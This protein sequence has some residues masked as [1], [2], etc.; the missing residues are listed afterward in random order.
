[1][2]PGSVYDYRYR[3]LYSDGTHSAYRTGSFTAPSAPG[4][5]ALAAHTTT[6]LSLSCAAPADGAFAP[7]GYRWRISANGTPSSADPEHTSAGNTHQIT[8]LT[9]GTVYWVEVRAEYA[10]GGYS[11]WSADLATATQASAVPPFESG[12][13]TAADPYIAAPEN[14]SSAQDIKARARSSTEDPLY[15]DTFAIIRFVAA[16]TGTHTISV[17][18]LHSDQDID[19]HVLDGDN[20]VSSASTTDNESVNINLQADSAC[21][22]HLIAYDGWGSGMPAGL[23]HLRLGIQAPGG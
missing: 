7:T 10:N 15:N 14:F 8:D 9:A 18:F 17:E 23:D 3:F 5:P 2:T 11:P 19:L 12:A 4:A 22:I 6:T 13:G 20:K 1:M 21:V 16:A